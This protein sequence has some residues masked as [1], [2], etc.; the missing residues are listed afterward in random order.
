MNSKEASNVV[1]KEQRRNV[2][3]SQQQNA[4]FVL[5][6]YGDNESV[7]GVSAVVLASFLRFCLNEDIK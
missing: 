2:L 3:R 7:Q 1:R 4:E 5:F 6:L